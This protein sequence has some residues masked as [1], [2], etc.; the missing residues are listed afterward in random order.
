MRRITYLVPILILSV[1][2]VAG[3]AAAQQKL[4]QTGMKFLSVGL[5]ARAAA[6]GDAFTAL[7]GGSASLFYNPA[8]IARQE[9]VG[10]IGLGQLQWIADIKHN[11]G[12]FTVS[13]AKGEYGVFGVMVQQVDYGT[14][15]RTV[16]AP[17]DKGYVDLGSFSPGGLMLGFAYAR[18]L[19]DKFS[20]GG[21]V[22]WVQ[23]DLGPLV[24]GSL[25]SYGD[26]KNESNVTSLFAFDFGV[27]YRTGFRSL[28]FGMAVRN[29]S[30]E[31]MYLEEGFQ[32]PLNF[33][34]GVSMNVL[35]FMALAPEKHRFIVAVDAEHPRDYPERLRM[36][37]EYVFMDVLS[38]RAGFVSL[39]EE[40]KFSYGLGLKKD[41]GNEM[42]LGVDYSYT[43]E[44]VFGKVH[45]ITVQL[46]WG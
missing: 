29:F 17:N 18:A 23:Q 15:Y 25:D 8:G 24:E 32:L 28:Q 38:L 45:R 21:A 4:A 44:G 16:R 6:L 22:K 14:L 26:R 42:S 31:G 30:K 36:G 39:A 34:I 7:D 1:C 13:P 3:P 11:F 27:L 35:D 10:A 20:I 46:I 5:D 2:L 37:G 40:E 33:R 19:S 12:S 41:V 43:P 9:Q